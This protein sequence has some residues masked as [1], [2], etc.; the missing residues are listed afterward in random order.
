MSHPH[1]LVIAPARLASGSLAAAGPLFALERAN[2]LSLS[3]RAE[4]QAEL[5]EVRAADVVLFCGAIAPH[6]DWILQTCQERRIPT[7]FHLDDNFW[8]LPPG[9]AN[10]DFPRT[11]A[12]VEQMERYLRRVNRVF[13]YHPLMQQRALEYNP[14]VRRLLPSIDLR[15][16]PDQAPPRRDGR[17]R[18]TYIAGRTAGDPLAK[19]FGDDLQRL[20]DLYPGLFEVIWWGA[21]PERF[22]Q[23]PASQVMERPADEGRFLQAL[24][25]GDYDIGLA[26]LLPTA[27]YLSQPP[28][29]YLQYGACRVAGLYSDVENYAACVRHEA[30]GM[31]VP[32]QPGAWFEALHGLV[33]N[34]PLRED[35]RRN[36]YADVDAHYRQELAEQEWLQ[37]LAEMAPQPAIYAGVGLSQADDEL[38]AGVA[39][40]YTRLAEHDAEVRQTRSDILLCQGELDFQLPLAS[41]MANQIEAFRDR[42]LLR[43]VDRLRRRSLEDNLPPAFTRLLDDSRIFGLAAPGSRL[44]FG[45][46]L[47]RLPARGY[48]LPVARPGLRCVQLAVAF[49]LYPRRGCLYLELFNAAGGLAAWAKK[50]AAGLRVDQP[51]VF[52]LNLAINIALPAGMYE[53]RLRLDDSDVPLHVYEWQPR[54]W[55]LRGSVPGLLAALDFM[56]LGGK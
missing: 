19:L 45:P 32:N 38:R 2:R 51:A 12:G 10:S 52:P 31:I 15:G 47:A 36:A 18:I 27:Y 42:R 50:P 44:D 11:P 37:V 54:G 1:V 20:L 21:A 23:H 35:L 3:L 33:V 4:T 24:A 41:S 17:V 6:Y 39:A 25:G 16:L 28:W 49:D 46:N 7:A 22:R 34:G 26:P 14:Q 43:W 13:V 9:L 29:Y 8:E 40:V 53:L 55:R 30:T 5:A 56:T 48:R